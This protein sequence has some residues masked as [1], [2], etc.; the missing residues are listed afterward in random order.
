MGPLSGLGEGNIRVT[1]THM[2]TCQGER[3]NSTSLFSQCFFKYIKHVL[4]S[5]QYFKKFVKK[6]VKSFFSRRKEGDE[7]KRKQ[8]DDYSYWIPFT[9]PRWREWAFISKFIPHPIAEVAE[10]GKEALLRE[11][12]CLSL[13]WNAAPFCLI[14]LHKRA[15]KARLLQLSLPSLHLQKLTIILLLHLTEII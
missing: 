14:F 7:G 4:F 5:L 12:S 13:K 9:P 10:G 8:V 15:T 1:Q 6:L 2:F 11:N 3:G